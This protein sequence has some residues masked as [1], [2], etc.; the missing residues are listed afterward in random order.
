MY[1]SAMRFDHIK[2]SFCVSY[3]HTVMYTFKFFNVSGWHMICS[4]SNYFV[5][6]DVYNSIV[7]IYQEIITESTL[8]IDMTKILPPSYF[9][10]PLQ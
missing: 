5:L 8:F 2:P 4:C 6:T 10:Y 1:V 3:D 9:S 7:Y